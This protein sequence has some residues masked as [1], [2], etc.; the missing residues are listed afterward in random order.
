[1]TTTSSFW[2]RV[3]DE[4]R[5]ASGKARREAERAVRA[6]VIQ[7]DLVSIRRDRRR[8]HAHLGERVLALWTEEKLGSLAVDSEALRLKTLIQSIE[9][10]IA[11]KEEELRSIRSRDSGAARAQ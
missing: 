8:A 5:T 7:M 9:G 11:A 4:V 10:L 6:G 2:N 3:Q 1:M